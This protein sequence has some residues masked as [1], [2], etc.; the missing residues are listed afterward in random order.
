MVDSW[1]KFSFIQQ[2]TYCHTTL[3]FT[4]T[5]CTAHNNLIIQN[6]DFLWCVQSTVN[7]R[8]HWLVTKFH[9]WFVFFAWDLVYVSSVTS[10]ATHLFLHRETLLTYVL[11]FKMCAQCTL[12]ISQTY[13]Y[14]YQYYIPSNIFCQLM[15]QITPYFSTPC[16]QIWN[17]VI[18]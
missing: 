8:N 9:S 16:P 1:V 13:M 17:S 4:Q 3:A 18:C 11:I 6:V 10:A 12:Y 5:W 14:Q 2:L 7:G 15:G